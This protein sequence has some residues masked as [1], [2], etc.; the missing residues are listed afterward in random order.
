M[1]KFPASFAIARISGSSASAPGQ[2]A[3][4][5][6]VCSNFLAEATK[7]RNLHVA[8]TTDNQQLMTV[9]HEQLTAIIVPAAL[10]NPAPPCF[11]SLDS[12]QA[13]S[14]AEWTCHPSRPCVTA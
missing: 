7:T 2:S 8:N 6:C 10:P 11:Q 13:S 14:V 12:W 4:R 1:D 9:D 5:M 3:S